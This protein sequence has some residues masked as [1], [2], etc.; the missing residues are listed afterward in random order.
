MI[1]KGNFKVRINAVL[2]DLQF[3]HPNTRFL[4][5]ISLILITDYNLGGSS[6]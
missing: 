2:I 5:S 6:S 4:F 1:M 3:L